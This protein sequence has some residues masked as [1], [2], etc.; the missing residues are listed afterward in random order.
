MDFTEH[1]EKANFFRKT[2]RDAGYGEC[3]SEST[4]Y[5]YKDGV[6]GVKVAEWMK[7]QEKVRPT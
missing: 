6:G 3:V 7:S 1:F 5:D 4:H 2:F